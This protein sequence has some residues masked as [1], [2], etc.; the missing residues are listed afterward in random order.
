MLANG[1]SCTFAWK[2]TRSAGNERG[3]GTRRLRY[4]LPTARGFRHR[5]RSPRST[6][7]NGAS[8]RTS[9][10]SRS[11]SRKAFDELDEQSHRDGGLVGETNDSDGTTT[12]GLLA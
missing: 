9:D 1:S 11:T 4:F 2:S 3:G 12:S 10:S 5:F 8:G 7:G 6:D